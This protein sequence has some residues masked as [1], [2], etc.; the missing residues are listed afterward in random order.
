MEWVIEDDE[1]YLVVRCS[2]PAVIA[3]VRACLDDVMSH[4]SW[5]DGGSVLVDH[6]DLKVGMLWTAE[7]QELSDLFTS[8]R[9][10]LSDGRWA[11]LTPSLVVFGLARMWEAFT[12]SDR[13]FEIG[14]FR[15]CAAAERWLRGHVRSSKGSAA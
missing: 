1:G 2:G 7:I 10:Q 5:H 6:S 15:K 4:P 11:I 8:R 13:D 14:I 3:D 9:E 12:E